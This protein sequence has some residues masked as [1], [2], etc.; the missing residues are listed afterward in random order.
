MNTANDKELATTPSV[1]TDDLLRKAIAA[2]TERAAE[3]YSHGRKTLVDQIPIEEWFA[4]DA[5]E[6]LAI[7]A[8]S[9][10]LDDGE[11]IC[12]DAAA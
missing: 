1:E 7:V 2:A 4:W 8:D 5:T 10:G 11:G 6:D 12:I 3:V 9:D